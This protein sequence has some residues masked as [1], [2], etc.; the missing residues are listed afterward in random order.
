M[1]I[2]NVMTNYTSAKEWC[3][4]QEHN[5]RKSVWSNAT[6]QM[7]PRCHPWGSFCCSTVVILGSFG[8]INICTWARKQ[9]VFH[10]GL[11]FLLSD[12]LG[13][14]SYG[15]LAPNDCWAIRVDLAYIGLESVTF[16]LDLSSLFRHF[17]VGSC[18]GTCICSSAWSIKKL[19]NF[20]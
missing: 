14:D 12:A 9:Q 4:I 17:Q 6:L 5:I 2:S 1:F 3:I 10:F 13:V 15:Y 18:T 11:H 8:R 16:F 7:L 20:Y 19:Q